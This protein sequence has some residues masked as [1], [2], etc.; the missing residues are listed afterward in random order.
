MKHPKHIARDSLALHCKQDAVPVHD[1]SYHLAHGQL[2]AGVSKTQAA[3]PVSGSTAEK[4]LGPV[5]VKAG[6]RSRTVQN[7]TRFTPRKG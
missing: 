4:Q 7:D 5:P 3:N 1:G 2:I 6:M